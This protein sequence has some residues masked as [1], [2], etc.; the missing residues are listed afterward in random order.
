MASGNSLHQFNLSVQGGT[1]GGSHKEARIGTHK[2]RAFHAAVNHGPAPPLE[3]P[4]VAR[5]EGQ[6]E[7][8]TFTIPRTT[9]RPPQ[10]EKK[11]LAITFLSHFAFFGC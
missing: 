9:P 10:M 2:D 6:H 7:V 8:P 5:G 3:A 11:D 1:Q 4:I